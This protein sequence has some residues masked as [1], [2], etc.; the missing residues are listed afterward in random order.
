MNGEFLQAYIW[1]TSGKA[2]AFSNQ[3]FNKYVNILYYILSS[4]LGMEVPSP[5]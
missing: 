1:R 4:V 2:S 3:S 5:Q